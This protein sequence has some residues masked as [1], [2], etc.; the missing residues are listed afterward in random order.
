M[1]DDALVSSLRLFFNS[2]AICLCRSTG[3]VVK[4]PT[5]CG[6]S[7]GQVNE[8]I[9]LSKMTLPNFFHGFMDI[10]HC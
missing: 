8:I 9:S 1:G 7:S 5:Q 10:I 6:C 2:Q 3:V 4:S